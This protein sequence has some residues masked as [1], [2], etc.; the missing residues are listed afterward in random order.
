VFPP[1]QYRLI[2]TEFLRWIFP[3]VKSP[4]WYGSMGLN[5]VSMMGMGI[6]H[7]IFFN[8]TEN[9]AEQASWKHSDFTWPSHC[10]SQWVRW[11]WHWKQFITQRGRVTELSTSS[12]KTLQQVKR[13]DCWNALYMYEYAE[14]RS[15]LHARACLHKL[16]SFAHL[17]YYKWVLPAMEITCHWNFFPQL[18]FHT[19]LYFMQICFVTVLR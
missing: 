16:K 18:L 19:F 6:R 9:S 13:T 15:F 4:K 7:L 5:Q 10:D 1:V 17:F 2:D 8:K 11:D 12:R 3:F 14:A